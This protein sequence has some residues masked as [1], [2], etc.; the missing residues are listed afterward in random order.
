VPSHQN[1]ESNSIDAN[2]DWGVQR[3]NGNI[4][5][6]LAYTFSKHFYETSLVL[7]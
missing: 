7:Q 2:D 3:I 6:I 1:N 4:I 5:I